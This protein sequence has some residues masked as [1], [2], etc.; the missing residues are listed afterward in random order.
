MWVPSH[1]PDRIPDLP[2]EHAGA[3]SLDMAIPSPGM[4]TR[5]EKEL[6]DAIVQFCREM[7]RDRLCLLSIVIDG[8]YKWR[9]V[10]KD[11]LK[12]TRISD[13]LCDEIY[14]WFCKTAGP[15][16]MMQRDSLL[17]LSQVTPIQKV[18]R[19]TERYRVLPTRPIRKR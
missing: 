7:E 8:K 3:R 10:A 2:D 5:R 13:E 12:G 16:P 9:K 18:M 17:R 11:T 1:D 15:N 6:H 14:D 19:D 4:Q